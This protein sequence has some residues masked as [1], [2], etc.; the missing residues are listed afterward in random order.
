MA[1]D[2]VGRASV[3]VGRRTDVALGHS[4]RTYGQNVLDTAAAAWY[5]QADRSTAALEAP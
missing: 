1:L 4:G 5:S 3:E 2:K